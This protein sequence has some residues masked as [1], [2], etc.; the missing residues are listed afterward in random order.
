MNNFIAGF[1]KRKFSGNI[2]LRIELY[3]K[4]RAFVKQGVPITTVV[5]KI[6]S[7]KNAKRPDAEFVFLTHLNETF[8]VGATFSDGLRGW[9]TAGEVM[10][11][12]SGEDTGD[13]PGALEMTINLMDAQ[14]KMKKTLKSNMIYPAVLLTLL[15]LMIYGFASKMLPILSNF[16]KPETWPSDAQFLA[17]FSTGFVDNAW[18]ILPG[19]GFMGW[20]VFK[21]LPKWTG[22]LRYKFDKIPP[23]SMYRDIE[24]GI[25]LIS[26]ATLMR[27]GVPLSRA[28]ISLQKESSPYVAKE[29]GEM[30]E[31]LKTGYPNGEAINT[32]FLGS[33]GD[34]IEIYGEVADFQDA[35]YQVGQEGVEKKIE[36]IKKGS[37]TLKSVILI[38]V[39]LFIMLAY[40][41]FVGITSN[42]TG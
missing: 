30:S 41:A 29:I 36:G 20:A 13:I 26:M 4:I 35:M 34:D 6:L 27:S 16:S 19:L 39:G 38:L 2:N 25:F 18:F 32:P 5:R 17:N 23:Y 33:S 3:R 8:K 9:A 28:L 24:S 42:V 22:P 12:S 7:K 11:I 40:S 37:G 14:N 31:R 10:L 1:Y 15:M 21:S